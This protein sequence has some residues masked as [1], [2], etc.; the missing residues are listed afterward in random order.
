[1]AANTQLPPIP[2]N[3]ITDV[4][5]WRDW[6]YQVSQVLTQQASIAWTSLNFTGSN[7]RD[8]VTRQHNALQDIQGG[9]AS[10]YYHLSAAQY[11]AVAAFPSIPL[12]V[13]NGGTG[14]T[15]LTGY[16]YGNGTGSF[17]ASTTIPMSAI[18]T[19]Y[20]AFQNTADQNLAAA[21][22]AYTVVFNTTDVSSNITRA[23]NQFT[24]STAGIYNIQFS[25]QLVNTDSQAH[26]AEIWLSLNGTD[27]TGTA[28]K[29][30]VPSSHGS[31]DGYLIAVANFLV[32]VTAGQYI[33]LK[34]AANQVENG[35]TNG[36]YLEAYAAQTTPYIRPSIPSSV[37]T[38][39][40]VD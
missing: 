20:G 34:I 40:Q 22:T 35:T 4:F 16:V 32:T 17:T 12:T 27:V 23:S 36:V 1:M 24:I 18:V 21:N 30:D 10:Q 25:L 29:Y 7:L 15:T 6:F 13:P 39:T 11:A 5:V 33:E 9:I 28:S 8:I 31:S 14:A 2:N 37:I 38:I 26:F 3:P 19:T